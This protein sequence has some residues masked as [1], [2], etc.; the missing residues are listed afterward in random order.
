[1][2]ILVYRKPVY[3]RRFESLCNCPIPI[4]HFWSA[5]YQWRSKVASV[6]TRPGVLALGRINTLYSAI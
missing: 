4:F 3:E 1:M 6:G 5:I 2:I